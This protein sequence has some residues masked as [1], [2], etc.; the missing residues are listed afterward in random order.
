MDS[1]VR[2]SS[3]AASRYRLLLVEQNAQMA[4]GLSQTAYVLEQRRVV[5]SG[6]GRDLL[7]SE[8]VRKACLG[9]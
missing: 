7:A 2:T 8:F 1:G 4:F 6:S 3:P 5:L 9:I